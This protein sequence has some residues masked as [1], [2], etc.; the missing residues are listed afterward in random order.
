MDGLT[1]RPHRILRQ[2]G[3]LNA[4][5]DYDDKLPADIEK[6]MRT[7]DTEIQHAGQ[8]S[9]H[10]EVAYWRGY[11]MGLEKRMSEHTP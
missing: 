11:R 4:L 3:Y 1:E 8:F 10:G 2:Q 9:L 5:D 6:A 7:A